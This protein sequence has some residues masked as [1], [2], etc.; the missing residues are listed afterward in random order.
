MLCDCHHEQ[1]WNAVA[2]LADPLLEFSRKHKFVRKGSEPLELGKRE[3]PP[4]IPPHRP[5]HAE[6]P[7]IAPDRPCRLA[8]I[9]LHAIESRSRD[10]LLRSVDSDPLPVLEGP[11]PPPGVEEDFHLVIR[12]GYAL[13][14]LAA[15]NRLG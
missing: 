9:E 13:Q 3:A 14:R 12:S 1:R 5:M 8:G 7:G 6:L 2:D 4:L 10:V 15:G 11:V